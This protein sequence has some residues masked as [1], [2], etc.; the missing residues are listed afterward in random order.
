VTRIGAMILHGGELLG[1][2]GPIGLTNRKEPGHFCRVS[3]ALE[4]PFHREVLFF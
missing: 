1:K 2:T 3:D 4:C